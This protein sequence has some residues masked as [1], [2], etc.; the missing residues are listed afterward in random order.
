MTS[1]KMEKGESVSEYI[2]RASS[3]RDRHAAA[4]VHIKDEDFVQTLLAGLP[5]KYNTSVVVLSSEVCPSMDRVQHVLSG[6]ELR[7]NKQAEVV[8]LT[9]HAHAARFSG[10]NHRKIGPCYICGDFGHL[11]DRCPKAR[12]EALPTV[13]HVVPKPVARANA[14]VTVPKAAVSSPVPSHLRWEHCDTHWR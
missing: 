5:V 1:L 2:N 9:A 14:A 3:M 12:A 4:G 13:V 8:H 11:K 6:A 10:R 7:L